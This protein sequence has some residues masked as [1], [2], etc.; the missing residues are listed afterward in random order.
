M[1]EAYYI[2]IKSYWHDVLGTEYQISDAGDLPILYRSLDE[3]SERVKGMIKLYTDEMGY[4]VVIPNES[5]PGVGKHYHYACRLQKD[6]PLIRLEIRL[7]T[8][9]IM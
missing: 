4:R 2:E 9:Y 1:Y 8:V 3:A 5:Y 6:S 7:Y